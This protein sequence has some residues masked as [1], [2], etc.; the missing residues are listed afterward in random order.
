MAKSIEFSKQDGG[1]EDLYPLSL[2][3]EEIVDG[4]PIKDDRIEKKES[5]SRFNNYTKPL[6]R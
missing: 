4:S 6:K 3:H 1:I 2:S 5:Y